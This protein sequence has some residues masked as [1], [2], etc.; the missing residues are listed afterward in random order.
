MGV[1]ATSPPRGDSWVMQRELLFIL[2]LVLWI[3]VVL[4]AIP[5]II[6]VGLL[7]LTKEKIQI[8]KNSLNLN[9]NRSNFED[10]FQI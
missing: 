9:K 8:T 4:S 2:V 6:I 7:K 1:Y 5:A 3:L 10:V